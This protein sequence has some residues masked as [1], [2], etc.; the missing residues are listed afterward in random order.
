MRIFGRITKV[1]FPRTFVGTWE[2]PTAVTFLFPSPI[3]TFLCNLYNIIPIV[4]NKA[5]R[6]TLGR[7]VYY[8]VGR[9]CFCI[10][11]LLI[12]SKLHLILFNNNDICIDR[13]CIMQIHVFQQANST[14]LT[15]ARTLF[16][17][18]TIQSAQCDIRH[19]VQNFL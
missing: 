5:S 3:A 19:F 14:E 17:P 8:N 6:A 16:F 4:V 10:Y 11:L 13:Q 7:P 1:E 9:P 12:M 2:K 18:S 15:V